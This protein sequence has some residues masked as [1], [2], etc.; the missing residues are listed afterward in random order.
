LRL[1]PV[2]DA[3]TQSERK[4]AKNTGFG[5]PP[6][7]GQEVGSLIYPIPSHGAAVSI[8]LT[9]STKR[10]QSHIRGIA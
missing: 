10:T 5:T 8:D 6:Y 9:V 1:P 7:S 4:S 3:R 2:Q